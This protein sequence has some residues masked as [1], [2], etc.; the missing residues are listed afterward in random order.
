MDG[1]NYNTI[2]YFMEIAFGGKQLEH[3][4]YIDEPKIYDHTPYILSLPSCHAKNLQVMKLRLPVLGKFT[5]KGFSRFSSCLLSVRR[6]SGCN[7]G[8]G[9]H[10][11]GPN[12]P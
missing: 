9:G 4:K 8:E 10:T 1:D 7:E 5:G 6:G 3:G 2:S 12:R 11:N